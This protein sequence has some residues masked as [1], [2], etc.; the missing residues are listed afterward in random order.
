MPVTLTGKRERA[1]FELSDDELTLPDRDDAFA[2]ADGVQ[3][4][5]VT[6]WHYLAAV[7]PRAVRCLRAL[8]Q[9]HETRERG[10]TEKLHHAGRV[11]LTATGRLDSV[12][13][14]KPSDVNE[15]LP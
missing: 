3:R 13:V 5:R 1:R 8:R 15:C 4:L 6:V 14:Q 12:R 10:G 9:R 2:D 11:P 7:L